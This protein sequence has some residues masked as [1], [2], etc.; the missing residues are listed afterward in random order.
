[1]RI[2]AIALNVLSIALGV[3]AY[4]MH[5]FSERKLGMVRWLNANSQAINDAV[6]LDVVQLVVLAVVAVAVLVLAWRALASPGRKTTT[7]IQVAVSVAIVG[8]YAG[9]VLFLNHDISRANTFIV[10][11]LG[12]AALL[13]VGALAC[14]AR[15]LA[16][17]QI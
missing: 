4:A 12:L 17:A 16:S 3:G 11:M 13:Q 5:Y 8:I 9:C 15:S 14:S 10:I 6:P 1:M 2:L 7:V